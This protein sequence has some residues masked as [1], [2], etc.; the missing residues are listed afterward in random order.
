ML[1]KQK[2]TNK[3]D[4]INNPKNKTKKIQYVHCIFLLWL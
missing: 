2:T 3:N 1:I 4:P